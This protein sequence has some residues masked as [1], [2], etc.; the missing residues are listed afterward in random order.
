M[1]LPLLAPL[2][3]CIAAV[4]AGCSAGGPVATPADIAGD[5]GWTPPGETFEVKEK[6]SAPPPVRKV[7]ARHLLEPNKAEVGKLHASRE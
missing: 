1:R 4:V 5:P 2:F 6:E 7:R 3:L